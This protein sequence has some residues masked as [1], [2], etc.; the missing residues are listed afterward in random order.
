MLAAVPSIA[1]IMPGARAFNGRAVRFLAAEA[2]IRQFLDIG[3]GLPGTGLPGAQ[4]S[5]QVAQSVDPACLVVCVN[6]DPMAIS[7]ARALL[8][9][10]R[11]GAVVVLD[12]SLSDP[13]AILAGAAATLD[14]RQPVAV[15]LPSTLAFIPTAAGASAMVS[16]LM[17]AAAPGSYLALYHLASDLDPGLPTA[18]AQWN[19]VSSEKI[20]LRSRAEVASL[21]AGLDLVEP[22]LVPVTEWR[23][24]PDEPCFNLVVPV[25]GVVA[26]KPV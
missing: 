22:G 14:F 2:G 5:H 4:G 11:E 3:T 24:A 19:W 18:V 15:L 13:A 1:G 17:T 26:R 16:A 25:Y 12:A 6:S 21:T 8:R 9:S 7:H 10:T 20:T 23:P